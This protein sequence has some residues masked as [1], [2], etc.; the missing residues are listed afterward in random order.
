[1]RVL[2]ILGSPKGKG[3]GYQ[4]AKLVEGKMR[5]LGEVE[6]EYLFLKEAG[7]GLCKGCFVCVTKGEDLCPMTEDRKAIEARIEE[8]DGIILVSPGY[9]QNVSWLMKNFMDRFAYTHHRPRFL[10][11]RVMIIANGGAGLDKVLDS[12]RIAIGGPEVVAE[13][14]YMKTPWPLSPKVVAKQKRRLEKEAMRFHQALHSRGKA[15]SFS[16]YMGFKFFKEI[17]PEV[18]EHLP[19][20]YA[21]YKEKGD[22]YDSSKISASKKIGAG[23]LFKLLTFIMR[24]MAPYDDGAKK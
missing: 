20:D 21:F 9:V 15:P 13:L 12:L 17:S 23:I 5:Q 14:A 16:S 3:T 8:A 11:K 24:D 6:F 1:M 7:L 18:R 10:N 22:Y 4:V 2:V 19:A